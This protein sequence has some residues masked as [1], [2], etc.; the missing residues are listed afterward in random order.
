M[1]ALKQLMSFLC[2]IF[3]MECN[4]K[5]S[6]YV[7]KQNFNEGWYFNLTEDNTTET[8]F[9]SKEVDVKTWKPVQ[10]PH[11]PKLEPK[12]VNDQWQ[13]I[14]WYRKSFELSDKFKGK[15]L[16]L[17]FEGAMN[18]AQVWVNGVKKITHYGGYLPFVVNFTEE[19]VFGEKNTI[20]VRLDNRDNPVTGPKSLKI[21]DFN[22]Y[23]GIHRNVWLIAKN[24]LHITDPIAVNKT[25]SGG[26]F[27]SFPEVSK[28]QA[29]VQIK[30][31]IINKK[32]KSTSF[33][34]KNTL[35]KDGVEIISSSS[36][37]QFLDSNNSK[38]VLVKLPVKKPQLW[39]PPTPNIYEL[40]TEI[41]QNR[42]VI[43]REI[44]RIGIKTIKFE[45]KDFYLNGKKTFLRGVNRHQE[46]PYIG[47]A[48]SDNAQYRDAKK[49]KD[50]GFD[51]VRL[52]HYP[53]AP[54]FME[55]CDKLGIIT[56]DAI[57]GWQYFSKDKNFQKHIFQT[58]RDL[59]RRDR[60]HAS[61]LAWE[62][63]LNESFMP[64]YF[65]DSLQ[66]IAHQE[67]P[68]NQCFSAGWQEYG[69]DIYLQARQHR[70]KHYNTDL[71]KPYSV[72][73]YGDWEYYAMNAGFNQNNWDELLQ[74]D[75][76]SR[77]LRNAGESRLLQQ[78]TNI[79]EAHNDN[80]GVS[81]FSDA[82]WVMFDYNRG[83][84]DDLESSGIMD[85]FRIPKPSFYFY[86][87]QR[88]ADDPFGSPMIYIA[89]NWQ[90]NSPLD[91]RVFSNCDEV[92]L[93]VNGNSVSRQ[94]PDK[95]N[96]SDKLA[97]P[98]FTF[99]LKKFKAGKLEAKGYINNELVVE[100]KK[101]TPLQ[102]SKIKIIT[103][104]KDFK[105]EAESHDY[106]FVYATITDENDMVIPDYL[107][108][109]SFS[110]EGDAVLIGENPVACEAGIATI[111]LKTGTVLENV[112][113]T[114]TAIGLQPDSIRLPI[115]HIDF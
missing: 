23:G 59:I 45:G 55:A 11:T 35:V 82:Y 2:L 4:E 103:D 96:I 41:I 56:I 54:A 63:S 83:Y 14:C 79:Q 70:L 86:K 88:D 34:L 90:K 94:K 22:T 57:L 62:V 15:E 49:I 89:N 77:Q 60:N 29:I 46:Y 108:K 71:E 110:I 3:F 100:T 58:A 38:T 65:I 114:A 85:I 101:Q 76:S 69:Y 106:L 18:I 104:I 73:E 80:L 28:S 9:S 16:F 40:R 53:H 72:S 93:F 109:I 48:L 95:N 112:K 115:R 20:A 50:A 66:T 37:S 13:G 61:V 19:I 64:E 51:Y 81:A 52:S 6:T 8:Q 44:T 33:Y 5:T 97:H 87:S 32:K 111:I 107:G 43:D 113:I 17:K 36:E 42:K 67:Y 84:A 98:P 10:L 26:V 24:P 99:K 47:Y 30:T 92:E 7:E 105:L 31:H 12:I 25:A 1:K 27:V 91:V 75:R 39:S 102:A 78:A 74:A 68:G 21:L